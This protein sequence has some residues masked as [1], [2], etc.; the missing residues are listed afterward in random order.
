[1]RSVERSRSSDAGLRPP[2]RRPSDDF[3]IV[4]RLSQSQRSALWKVDRVG[5]T[6]LTDDPW[7]KSKILRSSIYRFRGWNGSWLR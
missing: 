4:N 3:G 1:M 7:E 2:R 6:S 5:G